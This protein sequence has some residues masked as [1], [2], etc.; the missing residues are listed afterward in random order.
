MRAFIRLPFLSRPTWICLLLALTV[1]SQGRAEQAGLLTLPGKLTAGGT[2]SLT[3]TLLD[4]QT[5]EPLTGP[6][7]IDFLAAQGETL[8]LFQGQVDAGGRLIVSFQVPNV[9]SG[10]HRIRVRAGDG[11]ELE[12]TVSVSSAPALLLETDKPIYQPGQTIQG[13]VIRLSNSLAPVPG[14]VEVVLLDGKG[15]RIARFD[16]NADEYGVAPFELELATELNEGVWQIRAR[17]D[18]SESLR[19]VRVEHYVL[20]RFEALLNPDRAWALVDEP[21]TGTVQASYF[22]G[23][24]VQGNARLEAFR[25]VGTWQKYAEAEGDLQDGQWEFQLP[26]VDFVAGVPQNGGQGTIRLDLVVTDTTGESQSVSQTLLVAESPSVIMI[27]SQIPNLKPGLPLPFLITTETPG[28]DPVNEAVEISI[29][30]QKGGGDEESERKQLDTSGGQALLEV[31]PPLGTFSAQVEARLRDREGTAEIYLSAAY[32]PSDSFLYLL[33]T[34]SNN[35]A[36][37]G[38]Q[39]SYRVNSSLQATVFYEVYA[40]G[41]TIFSAF[42]ESDEF[43]FTITPEMLPAARIVAYQITSESEV[44]ADTVNLEVRGDG[45]IQI[46]ASFNAEEVRPGDPVEVTVRTGLNRR[47]L[48][49]LAIVDQSVLS[50]GRSR[51]YLEQVFEELERK[52]LAPLAAVIVDEPIGPGLG[53]PF[54]EPFT[55]PSTRDSFGKAGL[56]VIATP[57][58]NVPENINRDFLDGLPINLSPPPGGGG[59]G[60]AP[61]EPRVRQFFPETWYWNPTLLTDENGVAHLDLTA[62]DSITGW[63]LSAVATHSSEGLEMTS[64]IAFGESDLTVFQ[65]FF[66]EPTLPVQVTRGERFPLQID[67]FNYLDQPQQVRLELDNSTAFELLEEAER[68]VEVAANSTASI[69][70]PLRPLHVGEFPV[71]I[72]ARTGSAADAVK[73][74]LR[75]VAEGFPSQQVMN[76]VLEAGQEIT[77]RLS[78]PENAIPDSV[79]AFLNLTPS[80]VAQTMQGVSDLLQMPYGCGEQNMIFLAPDIE[81]LKYLREIGELNPETRAEAEH[82]INLGYQRQLTFQTSDGGFSAFGEPPS[83]LWLTAFVLSTF[84]GAREVRDID[85][86]VLDRAADLLLSRQNEDG[87]FRTD[88]FLIHTEL[89]GGVE[90]QYTMTAYVTNALA[91]Y[92]SDSV[93]DGLRRAADYLVAHQTEVA[94][95]PYPIAI[96]TVALFRVPGLEQAAEAFLDRLLELAIVEG[97]GIHWEPFPV[98]TTG[99]AAQ[100]MLVSNQGVG[101][102]ELSAALDWLV[103]Q[104]N[105]LGGYGNSTQ[106]T[107]VALRALFSAARN[108]NRDLSIPIRVT[109]GE[110]VLLDLLIDS[111]NFDLLHQVSLPL[112]G[113]PIKIQSSGDSSIGYQVTTRFNLPTGSLPEERDLAIDVRYDA[114]HI[115]VDDLVDVTVSLL[116]TGSK[117]RTGMVIADIGIPTG[118][119][120]V[121]D[122]LD[123]LLAEKT[124]SRAELAG[125]KVIFYLDFL[126]GSPIPINPPTP[127]EPT[128]FEFQIRALYPVRSLDVV[129]EAYEYYDS[130]IRGF[131]VAPAL[132]IVESGVS[133]PR[134]D[135][136]SE[137]AGTGGSVI[138]V[139]GSG[140]LGGSLEILFNGQ[141]AQIIEIVSDSLVR[142]R[143]PNLIPGDSEMEVVTNGGSG[144]APEGFKIREYRL[145]IPLYSDSQSFSGL[146]FSNTSERTA[147]IVLVARSGDGTVVPIEQNPRQLILPAQGQLA[148]LASEI[149]SGG[150]AQLEPVR[151]LEVRSD[152]AE[153]SG[154][155]QFGGADKLDGIQPA[156]EPLPEFWFTRVHHGPTAFLEQSASMSLI[157]INPHEADIEAR[158][159]LFLPGGETRSISRPIKAQ[160]TLEGTISDFFGEGQVSSGY[161][162]VEF[163][164]SAGGVGFARIELSNGDSV[165][166][167][168]GRQM[169]ESNRSWS[170]RVASIDNFF[171]HL[172]LVN[173]S[174]RDR[175]IQLRLITGDDQTPQ[176]ATRNIVLP[177]GAQ[178]DQF[179]DQLWTKPGPAGAQALIGALEVVADGP[180]VTGDVLFGGRSEITQATLLPLQESLVRSVLFSHVADNGD[181]F[182]GLALFNPHP[183]PATVRIALHRPS[184]SLISEVEVVLA[185]GTG[186]TAEIREFTA[187]A[188]GL[189]GGYLTIWSDL[190]VVVQ[191]MFGDRQLQFL[192]AV[193]ASKA[194]LA[195]E[196]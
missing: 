97:P 123:R 148:R 186:Q 196:Q 194:S 40:A 166:G 160:G 23:R 75:V 7:E 32:S 10:A 49:G 67:I 33:R 195:N 63:N 177:A 131:H 117:K 128:R 43:S 11:V 61:E 110:Q 34:D 170:A 122:S 8:Q 116:Y 142:V 94:A 106:D 113:H 90:N 92:G 165:V 172:K 21:I 51:L 138:E 86:L 149:W 4:S 28:G 157:V 9:P 175:S 151:W 16:L 81:I 161:L 162:K 25:W 41:R 140:F 31:V 147:K 176:G 27:R 158:L 112:D 54:F 58:L 26:A 78:I 55:Q 114:S 30:Y 52:F 72:T 70:F 115:E 168:N 169:T 60:A 141:A 188:T 44:I 103:T 82:F 38:G 68:V 48:L 57:N 185:A 187:A 29:R 20:P 84:S 111:S 56:Q 190:G 39:A 193:P 22:Y 127:P 133:P 146:A 136:I 87:S 173:L 69:E 15:I 124:V 42:T 167:L 17:S 145:Y 192:S 179:A 191:E 100:A 181:F 71:Q 174:T 120:V 135:S 109:A 91:E 119:G 144:T 5:H 155:F 36:R 104:R 96:A 88:D 6:V 171:T 107:V 13:R 152:N 132:Q 66:V 130:A 3:L 24:S 89:L 153:I 83:G 178:L 95:M 77:F 99:Y 129:S 18:G 62:P 189:T 156:L 183:D 79:S 1:I 93:Q 139:H 118:F 180:G 2:S 46:E 59:S 47:S 134:I 53:L 159:T 98:E 45:N 101:R 182:T 85:E 50:L 74:P 121:Q 164:G 37:L 150:S 73:R 143:V 105:S 80:A 102:P 125:R 76:S 64:G 137:S 184:G 14:P 154:T 19:D 126:P 108:L 65:G 35:P 12:A 163:P